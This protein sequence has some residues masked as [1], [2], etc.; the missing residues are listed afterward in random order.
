MTK[1]NPSIFLFSAWYPTEFEPLSGNFVHNHA[2]AIA[3]RTQ[4]TVIHPYE[5]LSCKQKLPLVLQED[6]KDNLVEIR[7]R[8]KG[9]KMK[10][11]IGKILRFIRTQR[12][13]REGILFAIHKYGLPDITHVNILTRAAL[14]ALK[15]KWKYDIP[16]IIT[17]H[18]SRYLPENND[19]KGGLRK[20]FTRYAVR[21]A[22]AVTTVSEQLK[23]AMLSH[24]LYNPYYYVVPN[25]I[26][27]VLFCPCP[28]EKQKKSILHISN[29]ED[30]IKNI[31]G[32]LRTIQRLSL[33]RSDFELTVIG[34]E[35]YLDF[36]RRLAD[37]LQILDKYV[38][39]K[40]EIP[41]EQLPY[42]YNYSDFH[43]LFSNFETQ[44][45]VLIE[46]FACGKPVVATRTGGIPDVVN[47]NNGLLVAPNDEDGLLTAISYMLDNHQHYHSKLIRDY[48][49]E[50]FGESRVGELFLSIYR[51][52]Y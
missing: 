8:Y 42:Y 9:I 35:Q 32:I 30:K 23:Q 40:E 39:F 10:N 37:N 15:L 33:L 28:V 36:A 12:A 11:S 21:K 26:D 29:L 48:A 7:I 24:C 6:I 13:Y 14:P 1:I 34:N 19:F 17:E 51:Q 25:A 47:E 44:G 20:K 18:W 49:V 16:F 43:L 31:S 41:N 2:K 27:D 46:S 4:I 22:K 45:L 50:N 5:D 38:F 3:K 52:I